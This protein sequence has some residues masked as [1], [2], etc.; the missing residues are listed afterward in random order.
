MAWV[1]HEFWW[2][3]LIEFELNQANGAENDPGGEDGRN[4]LAL[5]KKKSIAVKGAKPQGI[6][7]SRRE[8]TTRSKRSKKR[9]RG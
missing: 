5:F 9:S 7:K 4:R 8:V 6:S 1:G 3:P 2:I